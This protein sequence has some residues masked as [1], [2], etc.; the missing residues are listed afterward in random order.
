MSELSEKLPTI[1]GLT[2]TSVHLGLTTWDEMNPKM[3]ADEWRVQISYNGKEYTTTYRTGIGHRKMNEKRGV[4]RERGGYATLV[5]APVNE[6]TACEQGLLLVVQPNIA[7]VV[8]CL[9]SEASSAEEVFEEWCSG[10]GY[11]SD[12][13]KAL[14]VYLE[15][16]NTLSKLRRMFGYELYNELTKLSH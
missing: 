9:L 5:S 10:C 16:Q 15:C 11:S 1:E 2:L 6:K 8:S 14:N 3:L 13:R 12:S 7:D 4:K